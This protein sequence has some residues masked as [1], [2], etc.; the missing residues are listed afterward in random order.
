MRKKSVWIIA[1]IIVVGV[2]AGVVIAK[3][4]NHKTKTS[5]ATSNTPAPATTGNKSTSGNSPQTASSGSTVAIEN[6][7]FSPDSLVVKKGTA[8]TWTNKDSAAHKIVSDSGDAVAFSS[9]TLQNSQTYSF[10]FN[11]AGTFTYHCGVHPSMK[12]TV[13]ATQ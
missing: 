13:V 7:V 9:N 12:G 4:E 1:L 8:V 3:R 10:T 11:Q 6:F 2:A 5:T